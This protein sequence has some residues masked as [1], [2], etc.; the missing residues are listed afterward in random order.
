MPAPLP[1]RFGHYRVLEEIGSGGMGAVYR[2]IDPRLEREVAVKVLHR[3]LEVSGAHQR[4][5]REART[6]SS[7]NH[8]N[9]CTIF[10][11]GEQDGDPFL[12]MELL[13]GESLKDRIA[14]GPVPAED[15]REIALRVALALQAAHG[16][17]VIHRDIKPANIF[18]A[19]NGLGSTD[20]KVL[21][22][23]LAKTVGETD[24]AGRTGLTRLGA[25]VGTVEY[26]S[27]EQACGEVVDLRTDLFSLGAV[28][29]EMAT[30]R[31]PFRG[32][33]SA[34]VFSELLN[35]EPVPPREANLNL[36]SD[37]DAI[38][39]RLLVKRREQRLGSATALIEAL[40]Q[41]GLER[42]VKPQEESSPQRRG[43][44]PAQSTPA[45]VAVVAEPLGQSRES[46][47]AGRERHRSSS[48]SHP[49]QPPPKPASAAHG[50]AQPTDP[51]PAN[52]RRRTG[53]MPRPTSRVQVQVETLPTLGSM[54]VS[55]PAGASRL[56]MAAAVV[57]LIF[58]GVWAWLATRHPGGRA[59]PP[60]RRPLQ[61]VPLRNQTGEALLDRAPTMLLEL[62]LA[63]SPELALRA[64]A[65]ADVL[66]GGSEETMAHS[67][68][69]GEGGPVNILAGSV[70]RTE[71]GYRIQLTLRRSADS[72]ESVTEEGTAGSL[73]NVPVQ[74]AQMAATIRAE[75]GEDAVSVRE[76]GAGPESDASLNL[77]ALSL[78]AQADAHAE[79][80]DDAAA[81]SAYGRALQQAPE[82]LAAR[83]HLIALLLRMHADADADRAL[84]SL[85][86]SAPA[87]GQRLRAQREY[88]LAV[89]GAAG[90]LTAA[91]RW[92]AAWPR[93]A[94]ALAAWVAELLHAGRTGEAKAAAQTAA[95]LYPF[96][97]ETLQLL[98]RTQIETGNA[99]AA[100]TTQTRAFNAGLGSPELSL[101]AAY[102][103]D[104]PGAATTALRQ[105]QQGKPGVNALLA[106]ANYLANTGDLP[107]AW[108]RYAQVESIAAGTTG[109]TSVAQYATALRRWQMALAGQCSTPAE[110]G[111]AAGPTLQLLWMTAA[112]CHQTPPASAPNDALG[113]AAR[114]WL[115]EDRQGTFAALKQRSSD[116]GITTLLLQARFE[117]LSGQTEAAISDLQ[118]VIERRGSAYVS[119][120]IAY[121]VARALLV[122]AYQ[123]AGNPSAARAQQAAL[124]SI[125]PAAEADAL[126]QSL[127][128]RSR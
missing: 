107:T 55:K 78:L 6:V 22:F 11:I 102:L 21:D 7:L 103:K 126:V 123:N 79:L 59:A 92:H 30:G 81:L 83:L 8:P 117:M 24:R 63:E 113:R 84:D 101:A 86:A 125:W 31:L 57:L 33:T 28:L 9:I 82:L 37:L 104:D 47:A 74:I 98:T 109:A 39:R 71:D 2:A 99:D 44:E 38:I 97:S 85:A 70:S 3:N 110:T 120:T 46:A 94:E 49:P 19:G 90:A 40:L 50:V 62:L 53:E 87:G 69:D 4:F 128:A 116:E 17:G 124:R 118:R 119:G 108:E 34:I 45:A 18:L 91:S 93:D 76:H 26:M 52:H 72:S 106:E 121:P 10:D 96:R 25:T 29:Y 88:L 43:G 1:D 5:L 54:D 13:R 14:R 12:V 60:D 122:T 67:R 41:D 61:L 20:V 35:R 127:A 48:R 23:G 114:A 15:L 75:L 56:W 77:A 64:P 32:A 105:L 73:T 42:E 115:Q 111:S 16:R 36:P 58:G 51:E 27:P 95:N 68:P 65:A 89:R 66:E 100:W 80:G 112:W